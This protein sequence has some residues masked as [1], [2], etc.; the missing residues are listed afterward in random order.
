MDRVRFLCVS[1]MKGL[2]YPQKTTHHAGSNADSALHHVP[3]NPAGRDNT[4][5]QGIVHHGLGL[6]IAK[7]ILELHRRSIH[8]QSLFHHGTTLS[9]EL[10]AHPT[11]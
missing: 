2:C 8:V 3:R 10:P 4:R 5:A 1:K 6:A 11:A 9:F 7:R